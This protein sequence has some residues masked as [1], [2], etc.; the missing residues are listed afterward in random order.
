MNT[1]DASDHEIVI[2][3]NIHRTSEKKPV[4]Q[5]ELSRVVG[6]SLGMTNVILKKLAQKGWLTVRRINKR[7][8]QYAVTPSGIEE[9][10]HRSFSFLKRTVRNVVHYKDILEVFLANAKAKGF[11]G[12]SLVGKSD[13]DFFIEHL[14]RVHALEYRQSERPFSSKDFLLV[15][16]E[17]I[18]YSPAKPGM[19]RGDAVAFLHD[20]LI[21]F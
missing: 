3:E 2:L 7:N 15:F 4:K 10:A 8:I 20:I 17:D 16:S 18:G 21:G 6:I 13:F 5:R 11:R 14:C 12:I 1:L 9:I 19:K